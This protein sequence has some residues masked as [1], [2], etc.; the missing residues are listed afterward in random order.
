MRKW[1]SFVV[2]SV[3]FVVIVAVTWSVFL[4]WFNGEDLSAQV[5]GAS[6]VAVIYDEILNL[7]G[8][9]LSGSKLCSQLDGTPNNVLQKTHKIARFVPDTGYLAVYFKERDGG[10]FNAEGGLNSS[11]FVFLKNNG[12]EVSLAKGLQ[13]FEKGEVDIEFFQP[14]TSQERLAVSYEVVVYY[15]PHTRQQKDSFLFAIRDDETDFDDFK[16][17]NELNIDQLCRELGSNSRIPEICPGSV[18]ASGGS[19]VLEPGFS[20]TGAV[21]DPSNLA[22]LDFSG[23][24][25]R[26]PVLSV[27]NDLRLTFIGEPVTIKLDDIVDPD[28]KCQSFQF[29]WQ[30]PTRMVVSEFEINDRFGDL[31]FVPGNEG[32]FTL[33]VMAKEV[34]GNVVGNLTSQALTIRV[35]VN[36]KSTDFRDLASAPGFQNYIYDLYHISAMQGYDDGTMRPNRSVNRAEFLKLLFSTLNYDIPDTTY[37][38]RYP[39]VIPTDWFAPFVYQA[40]V[41]GVIKGYPDGKFHPERTINLAEALKI[42][43]QF[44]DIE[45]KDSLEVV[46]GDVDYRDW[47]SRYIQTAYREGILEDIVPGRNVFPNQAITRAKA[48]KLIVRSFLFPVNR[49]N[50]TNADVRRSPDE[51]EDFSSFDYKVEESLR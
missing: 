3:L 25:N 38:A 14:Y 6:E 9:K 29:Q 22:E 35:I 31:F 27:S 17:D 8:C 11:S 2:P 43:V 20:P 49:I 44:T 24:A 15:L 37:S 39:D 41:L 32:S 21:S 13:I 34:C 42:L 36:N 45:V 48:A 40:D 50:Y 18:E 1:I 5:T 23:R 12:E 33:R 19:S 47:Y 10:G 4:P 16:E 46:F 26:P 28:G 7:P 51:F 30:K